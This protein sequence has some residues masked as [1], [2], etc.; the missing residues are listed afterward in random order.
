MRRA[1]RASYWEVRPHR[2]SESWSAVDSMEERHER[3]RYGFSLPRMIGR[4]CEELP[5]IRVTQPSGRRAK[6]RNEAVG[7]FFPS[8]SRCSSPRL[9][10][11]ARR[12]SMRRR[13]GDGRA[14]SPCLWSH[15]HVSHHT[16]WTVGSRPGP[17]RLDAR[18]RDF[19]ISYYCRCSRRSSVSPSTGWVYEE[20]ST[21]GAFSP[22]DIEEEERHSSRPMCSLSWRLRALSLGNR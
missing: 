20:R 17:S 11:S 22:L 6:P 2:R 15:W 1:V 19:V 14:S 3:S 10:G 13:C 12:I 5:A 7:P 16:S 21:A 4:Y 9:Y 18:D 8:S